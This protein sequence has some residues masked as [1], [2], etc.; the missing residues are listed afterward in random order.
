MACP[1]T[2]S[3][4][5]H[6]IA[7]GKVSNK[8]LAVTSKTGFSVFILWSLKNLEG[9][10]PKA[11]LPQLLSHPP[12]RVFFSSEDAFQLLNRP[13]LRNQSSPQASGRLNWHRYL[14]VKN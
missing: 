3:P 2:L 12:S 9:V 14:N 5:L 6:R 10:L 1:A 11:F 7:L 8:L 4:V 13:E